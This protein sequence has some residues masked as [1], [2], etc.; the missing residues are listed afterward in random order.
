MDE[1]VLE[2]VVLDWWE[3]WP[4]IWATEWTAVAAPVRTLEPADPETTLEPA[5]E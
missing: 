2:D 1:I 3:T 4:T 5:D